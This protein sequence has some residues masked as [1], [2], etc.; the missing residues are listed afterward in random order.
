MFFSGKFINFYY[1]LFCGD[2]TEEEGKVYVSKIRKRGILT[3][4][5]EI[6]EIMK[7]KENDWIGFDKIT[8]NEFLFYKLIPIK[9]NLFKNNPREGGEKREMGED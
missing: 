2:K 3:V 6:R 8:D 7:L 1:I 5:Q 4:P 9:A